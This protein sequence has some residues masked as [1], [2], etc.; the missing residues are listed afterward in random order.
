MLL[1]LVIVSVILVDGVWYS[2]LVVL[3]WWRASRDARV[4]VH[5]LVGTILLIYMILVLSQS[6]LDLKKLELLRMHSLRDHSWNEWK[7]ILWPDS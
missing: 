6:F 3:V 2:S 4:T 7:C 5:I 1:L